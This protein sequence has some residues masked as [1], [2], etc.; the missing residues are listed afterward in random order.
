MVGGLERRS[1]HQRARG[2]QL[3]GHGVDGL[4]LQCLRQRQRRQDPGHPLGQ[5]R[6]AAPGRAGHQQVVAAGGRDLEQVLAPRGL[7][8]GLRHGRCQ[9]GLAAQQRPARSASAR[10][11]TGR[12]AAPSAA[13]RPAAR[14]RSNSDSRLGRAAGYSPRVTRRCGQGYPELSGPRP[15]HDRDDVEAQVVRPGRPVLGQPAQREDPDPAGLDVPDRLRRLAEADPAAGLDLNEDQV[16]PIQ[17]D[18]VQI[19]LATAPSSSTWQPPGVARP[20]PHPMH[21]APGGPPAPPPQTTI[22]V[23]MPARG[24]QHGAVDRSGTCGQPRAGGLVSR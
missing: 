6:L 3:T 18:E 24:R 19:A 10:L 15:A 17:R 21:P 11:C 13:S 4:D 5:Q 23:V 7:G 9:V 14:A 16:G 12:P 20:A 1:R 8:L 22:G 2:G